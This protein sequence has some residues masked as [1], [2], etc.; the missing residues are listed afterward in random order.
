MTAVRKGPRR[1][2]WVKIRVHVRSPSGEPVTAVRPLVRGRMTQSRGVRRVTA[3][4]VTA[5]LGSILTLAVR[6]YA[7]F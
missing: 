3:V 1:H 2:K 7:R 5:I 4:L 6:R